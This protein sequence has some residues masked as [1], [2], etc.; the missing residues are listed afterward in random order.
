M[1]AI[2]QKK[3]KDLKIPI[4]AGVALTHRCNQRC[5]YCQVW[6]MKSR[7]LNT[8]EIFSIINELATI[9]TRRFCL[10]GGEPLLRDDIGQI[11]DFAYRRNM[12][13]EVSSNGSLVKDKIS[14]LKRVYALCISLDGPEHI[15]DN[16]RGNGSFRKVME[17][18]NIAR[19]KK[20]PVYF[21]SVISKM[22][23]EHIDAI[24]NIAKNLKIKFIFQPA[25]PLIFGTDRINPLT[26][27]PNEYRKVFKKLII[28]KRNGDN[29]ILNSLTGL[30]YF[31]RYLSRWPKP[32]KISCISGRILF[33]IEPDGMLFPCIS[34]YGC[35]TKALEG[36]DCLKMG[37][38]EAIRNLPEVVCNGCWNAATF[39]FNC[40]L[41]LF[42]KRKNI[43]FDTLYSSKGYFHRQNK[44]LII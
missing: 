12:A 44:R 31:Y 32:G 39:E 21:R 5:L 35:N 27:S 37:V 23:L 30:R 7:E 25:T 16:V 14:Q 18:A 20:I 1:F 36:K 34:G 29:F 8:K 2:I 6:N 22:N 15:H 9:G 24:L 10:T 19:K 38:R 42:L 43:T 3:F 28:K 11:I 13:V 4:L 26:A 41:S 40:T 17:A 33:H